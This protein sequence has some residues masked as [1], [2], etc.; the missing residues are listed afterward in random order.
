[1]KQIM[2]PRSEV[3]ATGK[4]ASQPKPNPM[5]GEKAISAYP[6][7]ET[8]QIERMRLQTEATPPWLRK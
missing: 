6:R 8:F 4:K 1:M 2:P 3:S 5:T 7:C